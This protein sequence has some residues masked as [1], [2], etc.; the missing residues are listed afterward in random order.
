MQNTL[1]QYC[2]NKIIEFI[3]NAINSGDIHM[4]LNAK[5]KMNNVFVQAI[6]QFLP[7]RS[8]CNTLWNNI[9]SIYCDSSAI[10][11]FTIEITPNGSIQ[12]E[13]K[14]LEVLKFM[15][16][17][18]LEDSIGVELMFCAYR[19][20]MNGRIVDQNM[21]VIYNNLMNTLNCP[22]HRI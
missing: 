22:I 6:G 5:N 9:N 7:Y 1:R 2:V 4:I 16:K 8:T 15:K 19:K 21:I 13:T 3:D 14:T 10:N 17:R 12:N 20:F 18:I 11:D